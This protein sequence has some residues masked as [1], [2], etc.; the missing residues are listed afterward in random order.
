M[1]EV[2]QSDVVGMFECPVCLRFV[3]EPIPPIEGKWLKCKRCKVLLW[4]LARFDITQE[5]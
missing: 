4:L 3:I 5:V 1:Q 2:Q